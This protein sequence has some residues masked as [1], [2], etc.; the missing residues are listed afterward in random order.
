MLTWWQLSHSTPLSKQ[1]HSNQLR[2]QSLMFATY[3]VSEHPVAWNGTSSISGPTTSDFT[4]PRTAWVVADAVV[5]QSCDMLNWRMAVVIFSRK[6]NIQTVFKSKFGD[7][8]RMQKI[9]SLG[10]FGYAVVRCVMLVDTLMLSFAETQ[11]LGCYF[12]FHSKSNT[13][14][15]YQRW[16]GT[17]PARGCLSRIR[18]QGCSVKKQQNV[19]LVISILLPKIMT[20]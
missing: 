7:S 9:I 8:N 6:K 15:F 18:N 10:R 13:F 12:T 3:C 19:L 5:G 17:N 11:T 4:T 16:C 2:F 1:W 20:Q 14:H